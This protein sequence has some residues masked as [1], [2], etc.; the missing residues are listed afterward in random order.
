MS[1]EQERIMKHLRRVFVTRLAVRLPPNE[2][3]R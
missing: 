3:A 2:L 1:R